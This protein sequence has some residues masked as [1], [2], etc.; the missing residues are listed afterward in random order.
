MWWLPLIRSANPGRETKV[1]ISP[2]R[3]LASEE[4]RSTRK[5]TGSATL[6]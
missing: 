1:R 5:N 6:D 4:P 2:H 3:V